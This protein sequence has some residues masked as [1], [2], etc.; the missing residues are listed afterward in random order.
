MKKLAAGFHQD[1]FVVEPTLEGA[2]SHALGF[3]SR[4]E[5]LEVMAFLQNLLD[6]NKDVSQIREVWDALPKDIRIDRDE[7]IVGFLKYI[8]GVLSRDS[9]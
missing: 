3:L 4:T 1:V 5:R 9:R 7:E 6:G 2:V 8:M